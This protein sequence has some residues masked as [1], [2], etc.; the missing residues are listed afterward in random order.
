[1]AQGELRDCFGLLHL[2]NAAQL[3]GLQVVS[4]GGPGLGHKLMDHAQ[5][6]GLAVDWLGE[7]A[8]GLERG[9]LEASTTSHR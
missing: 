4:Q 1:M 2:L 3:Q 7:G 5:V 9:G 6:H 8:S